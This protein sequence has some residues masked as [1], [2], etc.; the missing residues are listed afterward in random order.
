MNLPEGSKTTRLGTAAL[1]KN[2]GLKFGSSGEVCARRVAVTPQIVRA[3]KTQKLWRS[4]LPRCGDLFIDH[5][6]N[7]RVISRRFPWQAEK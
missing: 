2:G 1:T 4:V 7:C 6:Y 5:R 3:R